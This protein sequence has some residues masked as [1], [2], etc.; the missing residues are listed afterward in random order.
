M[1]IFLTIWSHGYKIFIPFKSG[2]SGN[3]LHQL[4]LRKRSLMNWWKSISK[5]PGVP[6]KMIEYYFSWLISWIEIG[7]ILQVPAS[8]GSRISPRRGR[9]LLGGRQHTILPYFPKNCVKLKEFGPPQGGRVLRAPLR[10]AT[11]SDERVKQW[12]WCS[13]CKLAIM[14]S[15]Y[16][17]S[18]TL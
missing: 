8:G 18:V 3:R 7:V 13:S 16:Y 15:T 5:G 11:A 4:P 6:L 12:N 1:I 2:V 9:Q 14:L 17:I 10:Y